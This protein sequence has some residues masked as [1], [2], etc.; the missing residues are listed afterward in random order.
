MGF[1]H[2]IVYIYSAIRGLNGQTAKCKH[3][4]N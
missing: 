4:N 2:E 3:E 1:K